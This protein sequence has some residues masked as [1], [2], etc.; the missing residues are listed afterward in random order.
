MIVMQENTIIK[1][2]R[3]KYTGM[4]AVISATHLRGLRKKD[5]YGKTLSRGYMWVH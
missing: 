4:R 5:K 2:F 3:P 1:S